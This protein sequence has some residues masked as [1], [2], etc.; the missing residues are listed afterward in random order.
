MMATEIPSELKGL[1][2]YEANEK[3]CKRWP[4]LYP[5]WLVSYPGVDVMA[6]VRKA[7]AWEMANSLRRK[8]DKCRFLNLW[9]SKAQDA[10]SRIAGN[11]PRN[12]FQP[13]YG[14]IQQPRRA[15]ALE[16][17]GIAP[18][19]AL[20]MKKMLKQAHLLR[21]EERHTA[22]YQ[23]YQDMLSHR[24]SYAICSIRERTGCTAAQAEEILRKAKA[25]PPKAPEIQPEDYL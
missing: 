22:T 3:L 2:L 8:V 18:I 10:P 17:A 15:A 12:D 20:S 11:G 1:T 23:E 7:H 21:E 19:E 13:K 14:A 5:C 25:S 6:E 4:E 24:L 9:L 16:R